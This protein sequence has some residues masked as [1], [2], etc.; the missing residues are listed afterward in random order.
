[1][2]S[3]NSSHKWRP[4]A[5]LDVLRLRARVYQAI[6]EFFK[7]RKVLEVD[8]PC[9]SHATT[10]DPHIESF[11]AQYRGVVFDQT[12]DLY[13]G[14]SPEFHMKRL[15]AAGLGSIYQISH[16]FRQSELGSQ[17]NPE[18]SMLE[19]YR[20]GLNYQ[21]LMQE[22]AHLVRMLM[23]QDW[24][25]TQYLTYQQAFLQYLDVDPYSASID[26]LCQLS[27]QLG[28]SSSEKYTEDK[29]T[30]LDYLMSHH[31]QTKLGNNR[32]TFV[33][34]YPA[35]QCALARISPRNSLV[36]ERF[37]LFINGIELANGYQEL[38]NAEEQKLRYI[39]DLDKRARTGG[40]TVSFDTNLLDA[41]VV[42]LPDCSGV[43]LGLD[44]LIQLMSGEKR[45]ADVLAFSLDRA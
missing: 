2:D 41:M 31:V 43:A 9:L 34:E 20:V 32:L 23:Q 11:V 36:A 33:Y 13:L 40:K 22:V 27:R 37:E 6:R 18:F 19:W 17:H 24:S 26:E 10:T 38:T 45:L 4:N 15:V 35:S 8:T 30:Y 39:S 14:T 16:V 7:Q 21:D 25:D 1:M 12:F 29:D 42:G 28:Y 3:S 44:R 5:S